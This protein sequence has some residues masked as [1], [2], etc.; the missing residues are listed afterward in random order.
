MEKPDDRSLPVNTKP[1]SR[2]KVSN[3]VPQATSFSGTT[4]H[5]PL[6]RLAEKS[7]TNLASTPFIL[8]DPANFA[9]KESSMIS[10]DNTDQRVSALT[11][12]NINGADDKQSEYILLS[13]EEY[14]EHHAEITQCKFSSST[15]YL[16]ASSDME[17]VIKV[18]S[19]G[20]PG[21][22]CT[23]ATF[24]SNS[25]VTSMEWMPHSDSTFI[26]ATVSGN[27]RICDQSLRKTTCEINVNA[28]PHSFYG[29]SRGHDNSFTIP[30]IAINTSETLLA[31]S[32]CNKNN[33]RSNSNTAHDISNK[34]GSLV[35][36]D[37]RTSTR[38]DEYE[39]SKSLLRSSNMSHNF[40]NIVTSLTF[41][42]NSQILTTGSSDGKIRIFDLRKRGECISSWTVGSNDAKCSPI[43]TL[44][45][46]E[47]DTS[48]YTLSEDG[49]FST[50][51]IVQTS[52]K[53]FGAQIDDPY[54]TSGKQHVYAE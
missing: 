13:Q 1:N 24:V 51:S 23:L 52:Q 49:Y 50:W 22:P 35:L 10:N 29:D 47:D 53:I 6:S 27:I 8:N 39:F 41:N 14:L 45:R 21:P 3:M 17:G 40:S 33:Y 19:A 20:P 32:V 34:D 38:L 48:I 5:A 54:F 28:D 18:W 42:H 43:I 11:L 16:M 37:L 46:S 25:A 2:G 4:T 30:Q 9:P 26:Y 36:Y 31:A 12:D 7:S 15:G 44:Q